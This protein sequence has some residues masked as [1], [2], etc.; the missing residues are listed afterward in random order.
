M[1]P[2]SSLLPEM[3]ASNF[4]ADIGP[5][6]ALLREAARTCL[7]PQFAA[8]ERSE[9]TDGSVVTQADLDSQAFLHQRLQRDWP[10]VGF[11]GEEMP[12]DEQHAMLQRAGGTFWCLDPLDGT[13][14]FAAGL[15]F[16]A[17][18]LALIDNG[19]PVL[20]MVYDPIHDECFS[21]ARGQGAWLNEGQR[22]GTRRAAVPL[23]AC[24][25]AV[26]FKRLSPQL[27]QRLAGAPPYASQRSLGSV[28]LDWCWV[29]LGRF[30]VYL[31][32]KQKLWDYGAGSLILAE[33]GGHSL[34]LDG[35][36]VFQADIQPRSA[37]AALEPSLFEAW[38]AWL[39][40]EG[41]PTM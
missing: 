7:L 40:I 15:P 9:K 27:A 30:H 11:L 14:N 19:M 29:A 2:R 21:A 35:E 4:P 18:S 34:T 28:A 24:L 6:R 38:C 17:I 23:E 3:V 20:G 25:A 33:A 39:G 22:L 12:A 32:G 10:G 5:L 26:D 41:G 8:V 1:L 31:H 36:P 16:F 13:S 37:V